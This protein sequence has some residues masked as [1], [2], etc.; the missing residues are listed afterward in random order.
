MTAESRVRQP[1][2]D[3]SEKGDGNLQTIFRKTALVV[4]GSLGVSV[5]LGLALLFAHPKAGFSE[6]YLFPGAKFL[7]LFGAYIPSRLTYWI[8]PEG[9][10]DAAFAIV[11]IASMVLW[12]VFI[13]TVSYLVAVWKRSN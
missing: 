5:L 7:E 6:V 11:L 3:H 1:V 4:L 9:G 13:F 10:L 2:A 12:T 8:A